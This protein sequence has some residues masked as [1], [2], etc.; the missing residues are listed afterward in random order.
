MSLFSLGQV[1]S[2]PGALSV[3]KNYNINPLQ[4]I[5]RHANGDWGDLGQEDIQ[6]NTDAIAYGG[7]IFSS[8]KVGDEKLY[9]ITEHDFSSTTLL[10]ADEY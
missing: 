2:T 5:A 8:Y 7:R 9:L 1:V 4:L 6:A 10:R 3:C